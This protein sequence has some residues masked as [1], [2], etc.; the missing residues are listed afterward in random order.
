LIDFIT[1]F[2]YNLDLDSA[3]DPNSVTGSR[4]SYLVFST[5]VNIKFNFNTYKNKNTLMQGLQEL[6]KAGTTDTAQAISTATDMIFTAANGDRPTVPNYMIVITDGKSN[7][8]AQTIL[9][10]SMARSKGIGIIAIGVAAVNM[11]ELRGIANYPESSNVIVSANYSAAATDSIMKVDTLL[12]GSSDMCMP[13]PCKNG[14]TCKGSLGGFQCSPCPEQFTG[15][16]CDRACSGLIDLILV[17]DMSGSINRERFELVKQFM[18]NITIQL[19]VNP[20]LTRVGVEYFADTVS[21]AFNLK[22]YG[23][24]PD[25]SKAI[26]NI[27]FAGG[28]TNI[29]AALKYLR[30]NMYLAANG[31]RDNVVKLAIFITDAVATVDAAMTIPEAILTRNAGIETVIVLVGQ[32]NFVDMNTALAIVSGNKASNI[33]PVASYGSL[34]TVTDKIVASTCN[35]VNECLAS[36]CK[37]SG[38]C[39]D[40][41]RRYTCVCPSGSTGITCD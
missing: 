26:L 12:C 21:T 18:S 16:L 34:L 6:F 15:A 17:L 5:A 8:T 29:A 25:V 1:A 4:I 10:A 20:N 13:N 3:F 36:P 19:D 32:T 31:G 37:N 28:K 41:Y 7:S 23:N 2:V 38:T 30:E 33:I 22:D 24:A 14:A 39:V 35:D 27:E 9:Q 11:E 40:G